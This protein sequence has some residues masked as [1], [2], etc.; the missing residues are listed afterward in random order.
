M[1]Q[2]AVAN[3][4]LIKRV[5]HVAI[6]AICTASSL[7]LLG[8]VPADYAISRKTPAVANPAAVAQ[9]TA[10]DNSFELLSGIRSQV[11]SGVKALEAVAAAAPRTKVMRMEVTAYCPCTKCCGPKAQGI[12]A[13]GKHVSH[14]DGKFVAADTSILPF[15]T[16]L[17]VPGY[18]DGLKVE[19][20]D[21][22]GAIKGN[23]LDLFFPTHAEAL[24]WGR[25]HVDVVVYE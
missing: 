11:T 1:T 24:V 5:A 18:A 21:R 16:E 23:K 3:P 7:L 12:T 13:S 14:N 4:T 10:A 8:A 6:V 19:V 9:V 25:Q 2:A 15:G 20:A 22:G 17:V